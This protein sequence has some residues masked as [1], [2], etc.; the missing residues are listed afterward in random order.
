[1]CG[2]NG[3]E[4]HG[5]ALA[6]LSLPTRSTRTSPPTSAGK[7]VFHDCKKGSSI[8]THVKFTP[9]ESL[10]NVDSL[11]VAIHETGDL[12]KSAIISPFLHKFS[13][14]QGHPASQDEAQNRKV[15][16]PLPYPI[17][18]EVGNDGII[19]RRV[20]LWSQHATDPIAEGII[21]YN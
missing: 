12:T 15:E 16:V 11:V 19:G 18:I 10:S 14:A 13:M 7:L 4:T 6:V 5:G 9:D 8:A 21:G 2:P 17:K 20:S 3:R 1:M